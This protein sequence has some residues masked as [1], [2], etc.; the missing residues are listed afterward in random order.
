MPPKTSNSAERLAQSRELVR[1]QSAPSQDFHPDDY[2]LNIDPKRVLYD[3]RFLSDLRVY[4]QQ[5]N[6]FFDT[7]ED[8]RDRFYQDRNFADLNSF[9]AVGEAVYAAN[10]DPNQRLRMRRIEN[11]WRQM[12]HFWQEGGRGWEAIPGVAYAAITDPLNLVPGLSGLKAGGHAARVLLL[13]NRANKYM[14]KAAWAGAQ[15]GAASEG[16]ISG[17][18]EG[19]IDTSRQIRDIHLGLQDEYS[20]GRGALAVGVG[21]AAGAGIGSAIGGTTGALGARYSADFQPFKHL[22]AEKQLDELQARGYTEQDITAMGPSGAREFFGGTRSPQAIPDE[23]YPDI[24]AK[25]SGEGAAVIGKERAREKIGDTPEFRATLRADRAAEVAQQEV[26]AAD[27]AKTTEPKLSD[28]EE[29]KLAEDRALEEYGIDASW[30]DD[31]TERIRAVNERIRQKRDV[32]TDAEVAKDTDYRGLLNLHDRLKSHQQNAHRLINQAKDI[33]EPRGSSVGATR[34]KASSE[35]IALRAEVEDFRAALQRTKNGDPETQDDQI[36]RAELASRPS[37]ETATAPDVTTAEG[38]APVVGEVPVE[39]LATAQAYTPVDPDNLASDIPWPKNAKSRAKAVSEAIDK[40]VSEDDIRLWLEQHKNTALKGLNRHKEIG[41]GNIEKIPGWKEKYL[42]RLGREAAKGTGKT[43]KEA[44]PKPVDTTVEP[45]TTVAPEVAVPPAPVRAIPFGGGPARLDKE[46]KPAN[47]RAWAEQLKLS[48]EDIRAYIDAVGEEDALSKTKKIGSAQLKKIAKWKRERPSTPEGQPEVRLLSAEEVD[49][50]VIEI[51]GVLEKL[52]AGAGGMTADDLRNTAKTLANSLQAQRGLQGTELEHAVDSVMKVWEEAWALDQANIQRFEALIDDADSSQMVASGGEPPSEIFEKLLTPQEMD[53]YNE[54][55]THHITQTFGGSLKPEDVE[56]ARALAFQDTKRMTAARKVQTT[57]KKEQ[58]RSAQ[59]KIQRAALLTT[60]GKDP[61]T[62]RIQNI[63][64]SGRGTEWRDDGTGKMIPDRSIIG[65]G[66]GAREDVNLN[67]QNLSRT[68]AWQIAEKEVEPYRELTQKEIRSLKKRLDKAEA[69]G[70]EAGVRTLSRL[71]RKPTPEELKIAF[72]G[73]RVTRSGVNLVDKSKT[74]GIVPYEAADGE[75]IH[76]PHGSVLARPGQIVFADI[77][78]KQVFD[79]EEYALRHRGV[80]ASTEPTRA[81]QP[82]ITPEQVAEVIARNADTPE[83]IAPELKAL[84]TQ[85]TPVEYPKAGMSL[86]S[87]KG[88]MV[89]MLRYKGKQNIDEEVDLR[90]PSPRQIKEGATIKDIIGQKAG[91]KSDPN[92][93]EKRWVPAEADYHMINSRLEAWEQSGLAK[94]EVNETEGRVRDSMNT[95]FRGDATGR[96]RPLILNSTEADG[97]TVRFAKW[98]IEKI[99][100][101]IKLARARPELGDSIERVWSMEADT[102]RNRTIGE[103]SLEDEP[104]INIPVKVANTVVNF[105]DTQSNWPARAQ[106]LEEH[107]DAIYMLHSRIRESVPE[108][109]VLPEAD[110]AAAVNNIGKIFSRFDPDV[111]AEAKSFIESLGGSP[112]HAPIIIPA[113]KDTSPL[114]NA[115]VFAGGKE[116]RLISNFFGQTP[117]LV[118]GGPVASHVVINPNDELMPALPRLY[119]EVAHW[120]YQHILTPEDRAEFWDAMRKYYSPEGGLRAD[121]V[122]HKLAVKEVAPFTSADGKP[123]SFHSNSTDSPQEFFAQQFSQWATQGASEGVWND[124]NYWRRI[125]AYVKDVFSRYFNKDLIDPDLEPLFSKILPEPER[126]KWMWKSAGEP[127][128]KAGRH[129]LFKFTQ[130]KDLQLKLEIALK[131]KDADGNLKNDPQNIVYAAGEIRD[132]IAR[133]MSYD[134]VKRKYHH[135]DTLARTA[136][137]LRHR[138]LDLS[139]IFKGFRAI[140][141]PATQDWINEGIID[142]ETLGE[143]LGGTH[144][145]TEAEYELDSAGFQII[146]SG[147]DPAFAESKLVAEQAE[148]IRQLYEGPWVPTSMAGTFPAKGKFGEYTSD[149]QSVVMGHTS[150]QHAILLVKE[151]LEDAYAKAEGLSMQDIPPSARG[152]GIKRGRRAVNQIVRRKQRSKANKKSHKSVQAASEKIRKG[153]KVKPAA[154]SKEVDAATSQSLKSLT[155][156]ELLV[157]YGDHVGTPKGRQIELFLLEKSKT[158]PVQEQQIPITK[159]I[160]QAK[161]HELEASYLEAFRQGDWDKVNQLSYEMSRR[162][163]QRKDS[164]KIQPLISEMRAFVDNE[165]DANR[166]LSSDDGI[167][168]WASGGARVMLSYLTHRD[169]E[170][171][172]VARTMLYRMLNLAGKSTSRIGEVNVMT[173][174]DVAALAGVEPVGNPSAVFSDFTGPEFSKLRKDLRKLSIGLNKGEVTPIQIMHEIG[175]ATLRAAQFPDDEMTAIRAAFKLSGPD[176][177][178]LFGT[179]ASKNYPKLTNDAIEDVAAEE[180]FVE[181]WAQY[182]SER[183]TKNDAFKLSSDTTLEN[184]QLRGDLNKAVD[185]LVEYVSYVVNGLIGRDDIKQ[186]YRRMMF[187]GDMFEKPAGDPVYTAFKGQLTVPY[188]H[189]ARVARRSLLESSDGR[190]ELI[191]DFVRTGNRFTSVNGEPVVYYHANTW[192]SQ[193]LSNVDE[194]EMS[195]SNTAGRPDRSGGYGISLYL[196]PK[197]AGRLRDNIWDQDSPEGSMPVQSTKLLDSINAESKPGKGWTKGDREELLA[198]AQDSFETKQ[199]ISEIQAR[200][201]FQDNVRRGFPTTNFFEDASDTRSRLTELLDL[202]ASIEERMGELG[203]DITPRVTPTYVRAV[204]TAAFDANTLYASDAPLIQRSLAWLHQNRIID[205]EDVRDFHGE[206]FGMSA[207]ARRG[208]QDADYTQDTEITGADLL[209]VLEELI[210]G[211]VSTSRYNKTNPPEVIRGMLQEFG[212]DSMSIFHSRTYRASDGRMVDAGSHG[213]VAFDTDQVRHIEAATFSDR[214]ARIYY[215]DFEGAANDVLRRDMNNTIVNDGRN[216]GSLPDDLEAEGMPPAEAEM[217]DR[218][219]RKRGPFTE[220]NVEQVR[221]LSNLHLRNNSERMDRDGFHWAADWFGGFFPQHHRRFASIYFKLKDQLQELPDAKNA[222]QRWGSRIGE[223]GTLGRFGRSAAGRAVGKI[224]GQPESWGRIVRALRR[225][226]DSRQFKSLTTKERD[227]AESIQAAFINERKALVAAGQWMG[228][229]GDKYFPQIWRGEAIKANT[230]EFIDA[231]V[232]Y[233]T[234]ERLAKGIE[235]DESSREGLEASARAVANRLQEDTSDGIIFPEHAKTSSAAE[236]IDFSR[237]IHLDKHPSALKDLE[238]FLEG[239]IDFILTKY[240]EASTRRYLMVDKFGM[241]THGLNDYQSV[242]SGGKEAI[243]RLLTANKVFRK[244]ASTGERITFDQDTG[245][246]IGE[247]GHSPV[248]MTLTTQ[249]PFSDG[250][251]SPDQQKAWVDDIIDTH[252]R[253]GRPGAE[254]LL[255]ELGEKTLI[256]SSGGK[257]PKPYEVRMEAILGALDDSKTPEGHL[258][259][260]INSTH[261]DHLDNMMSVYNKKPVLGALGKPGLQASRAIRQFNNIT[262]LSYTMF[263]S[264]GDVIL[265]VIRSGSMGSA[266]KAWR[267]YATDSDYRTMFRNTG[268][269]IE[270]IVHERMVYGYGATDGKLSTAFHNA[271]L[272][273]PWTDFMSKVSAAIGYESFKA[274][275]RI[276][277]AQYRPGLPDSKQSRKYKVARRFLRVYGL[278]EYLPSGPKAHISLDGLE[279]GL[280]AATTDASLPDG[281]AHHKLFAE[282]M[283]KFSKEATFVPNANDVPHW[284]QTPTMALVAQLK[285]F[286]LM[287]GRLVNEV[288]VNDTKLFGHDM[289]WWKLKDPDRVRGVGNPARVGLLFTLGPAGGLAANTAKDFIQFRGGEDNRS[290]ETRAHRISETMAGRGAE[291]F[292]SAFG[293]NPKYHGTDVDKYIGHYLMGFAL[294]GGFGL[295]GDMIHSS[296]ESA[297]D[298]A[299]G[300]LRMLG[301]LGGPSVGL[302]GSAWNT[303]AGLLDLGIEGTEGPPGKRRQ[304]LREVASRVPFV[305]QNRFTRENMVDAVL[306]PA[307]EKSSSSGKWKLNRGTLR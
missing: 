71:L 237:I 73:S 248:M 184:V 127:E 30:R 192:G 93:W 199:E 153:L 174:A 158:W 47:P 175:H 65:A 63:L 111:I 146:D 229:R 257:L 306:P 176:S 169:P 255:R 217:L 29:L 69:A 244:T 37:T 91:P 129:H 27:A 152:R 185:R 96:G 210:A 259:K 103:F 8:L 38:E 260:R 265:P 74:L 43:A 134:T 223:I 170:I 181:G 271:T 89:I 163:H 216:A 19:A 81:T 243:H 6:E 252:L 288:L 203:V 48:D 23:D 235:V 34:K 232:R 276:A 85:P 144:Q 12:P 60:A 4:Y 242:M 143:F 135:Y 254:F 261:Y 115:Y 154:A 168:Q 102:V 133:Q 221:L 219:K 52:A 267:R 11:V 15:R 236:N 13:Q 16:I 246:Y 293:Y 26:D 277:N 140:G 148:E 166:G 266:L 234:I 190:R 3:P 212:Y 58:P 304:A 186:T 272:L 78:Q 22:S 20:L 2:S 132:W 280:I 66:I 51:R 250:R 281:G 54:R 114:E 5:R 9:S 31:L 107:I 21:A 295:F 46:G 106:D 83:N 269:A 150:L 116:Q 18:Q 292:M 36:K 177:R 25:Y 285:T 86:N 76:S 202:D 130:L 300:T 231:L 40:R 194:L 49:G 45:D 121:H 162:I 227:V 294:L 296:V 198:L 98:E 284:A 245:D 209:E 225:G 215:S 118:R 160:R 147:Y 90:V 87:P 278:E 193:R 183:V 157:E 80:D 104:V 270:N 123:L 298:G 179:R 258:F 61:A 274:Q 275:Q 126:L 238:P 32:L 67:P 138:L 113:S 131:N 191:S 161:K 299:Y 249:M 1:Q 302:L 151:S 286:P 218:W 279:S 33:D 207:A 230:P 100:E 307:K 165:I 82:R 119:H 156:T 72:N 141:D 239:D 241:N 214:D 95:R 211:G 112:H 149:S 41:A 201:A 42:E 253:E 94:M 53:I 189:A 109:F 167:P 287:M 226:N 136:K 240:F 159:E 137:I 68:E 180:W 122:R 200:L 79:S 291:A 35:G 297:D 264:M 205:D 164:I 283:I 228:D 195:S 125:A 220:G 24:T 256:P 173:V 14:A 172:H 124:E 196:E 128:T 55:L 108:G 268:T 204:N 117:K 188:Q 171:Q 57:S 64:R 84:A 155:R 101:R 44:T 10:T 77:K 290:A 110:R 208:E 7:D 139:H 305:G 59:A 142:V 105:L 273:T 120:A 88:D 70:D 92:M 251:L 182:L 187:Y 282:A 178:K 28:E 197:R 303:G 301:A 145:Y 224:V 17:V 99:A 222:A 262:L 233:F 213:L 247:S 50:D 289:G 56:S 206:L 75:R 97:V 62:G 39:T 263:T